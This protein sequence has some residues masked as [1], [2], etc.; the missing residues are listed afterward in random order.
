MPGCKS[1]RKECWGSQAGCVV[2]TAWGEPM[3]F[4]G[5]QRAKLKRDMGEKQ[6][7]H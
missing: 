4:P 2:F 1:V 6:G 3:S 5:L 7:C